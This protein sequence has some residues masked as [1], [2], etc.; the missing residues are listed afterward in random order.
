[1]KKIIE[2]KHWLGRLYW[3]IVKH[4]KDFQYKSK[5]TYKLLVA[6][7]IGFFSRMQTDYDKIN[8]IGAV[9]IC[10]HPDDETIFFSSIIKRYKPYIICMSSRGNK[11]RKKEF[12]DALNYQKVDG[13]MWNFPDVPPFKLT[14]MEGVITQSLKRLNKKCPNIKIIYTHNSCGESGNP[15]HFAISRAVQKIFGDKEV[16]LTAKL[17]NKIDML[18]DDQFEKKQYIIKNIYSSQY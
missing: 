11:I 4:Y 12:L 5:K 3:V 1:M 15:N 7:I 17:P 2:F 14:Q 16:Y 9:I 8:R 6:F 13:T 18:T 10:A